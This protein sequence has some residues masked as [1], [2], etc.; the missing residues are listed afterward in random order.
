MDI[1]NALEYIGTCIF[2]YNGA[3]I[4]LSYDNNNL[5]KAFIFAIISGIGGGSMR[6]IIYR[7]PLFW[8]TDKIYIVLA[9]I[10]ALIGVY[11]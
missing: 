5:Y 2:A 10:S 8:M 9:V 11:N 1:Y 3:Q 4:A 7:K 6:D